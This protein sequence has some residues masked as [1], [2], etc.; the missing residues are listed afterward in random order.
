MA[1]FTLSILLFCLFFS[2]SWA[3]KVRETLR[4]TWA[5]GAPNGQSRELIYTNGQFPGP[6]LIFTEGD[7]VE[8]TVINDMPRNITV[9][10]HG[11]SLP[12]TPWSDGVI[13]LSQTPILSGGEF[14]YKFIADPVGTHWYHSHERM[15]LTDGLYGAILIKPKKDQVGLWSQI[16]SNKEDIK[17]MSKAAK[18]PQF[19]VVSDWSRFTSVEYW[20]ANE[21]AG[22]LIFCVDSILVNGVGAVYCPTMEMLDAETNPGVRE[23][24]FGPDD[25]V[26]DKGC[27]PFLLPIEGGPWNYTQHPEL[28]P[29][30]LQ[31]GCVPS[32]G[33]NATI[34]VDAADGWVSLNF[35]AAA[36][37]AQFTFSIDEHDFW[38]YEI[39]GN[40]VHPQKFVAAVMSAGETFSVMVKLDKKPGTY[41]IRLPDSGGTQVISAFANMVYKGSNDTSPTEPYVSYGG[42]PLNEVAENNS[43]IPYELDTDHMVPWPAQAPYDGPADEEYLLVLGRVASAYNYTMNT[44]A[45]YPVNFQADNPLI[46]NPNATLGTADEDLVIRTKN[47]SWVDIILQVSTLPGDQAAFEHFIHKH[48]SKTWRIGLGQGTWNYSSVAEARLERPQ[49]FNLVNPGLRDTWITA[50]SQGG[51]YWSVLRYQVN[52][53]GPWL[54]HCHVE[55][56]VMGGMSLA[57]LDGVDKWPEVP[58][59]YQIGGNGGAYGG[60]NGVGCGGGGGNHH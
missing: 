37:I 42:L 31:D 7:H 10:W 60:G 30:H 34:E 25:H 43:F 44:K 23:S 33:Q 15:S 39:D 27:L 56:H 14:V 57:I 26:S 41:T 11:L 51:G 28:I 1:S 18:D 35:V 40:Y 16:S 24:A 52:N 32:T 59:E 2:T 29:P 22:L 49:D 55:L 19:M 50:F 47:G 45:M 58:P 13:G 38:L 20:K 46:F 53:P 17:A 8:I 36:T 9:H 48:G 54:F 3:A 12:G 6:P 4:F 21:E 5:E